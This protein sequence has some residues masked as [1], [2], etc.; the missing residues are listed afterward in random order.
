MKALLFLLISTATGGMISWAITPDPWPMGLRIASGVCLGMATWAVK[1][2]IEVPPL[3]TR[4][5]KFTPTK[6]PE[7]V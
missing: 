5:K 6:E 4:K 2:A 3:T 7:D 1:T